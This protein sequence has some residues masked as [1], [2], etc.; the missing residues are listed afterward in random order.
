MK[1][2]HALEE[3]YV[4]TVLLM[5]MSLLGV[6]VWLSALFVWL[7]ALFVWL[8]ALFVWL[9]ALFVWLSALF[10]GLDVLAC[11]RMLVRVRAL[12]VHK[13]RFP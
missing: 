13:V 11:A 6:F 5:N 12:D 4:V 3:G 8:S 1:R 9:S 2:V 7:S 10:V